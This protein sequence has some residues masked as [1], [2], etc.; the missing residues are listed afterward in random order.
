MPSEHRGDVRVGG[1]NFLQGVRRPIVELSIEQGLLTVT[2]L[3]PST[4]SVH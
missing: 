2:G 4:S 3:E 1:C